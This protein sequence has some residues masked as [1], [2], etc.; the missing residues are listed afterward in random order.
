MILVDGRPG[1]C[2]SA[3]DRGFAY[4]DGVFRTMRAEAGAVLL[5]SE[6]YRKLQGDCSRL[7]IPCPEEDVLRADLGHV[8]GEMP[9]CAVKIIVTRGQ[10]ARGYAPPA[11]CEPT[12]VVA[13][14]PL[15]ANRAQSAEM[16]VRVRWCATRL[17]EQPLLAGVKHLNR[18]E[19]VLA[20][21][22]WDDPAI[23]EGLMCDAAGSVVDG[24]M[25]NV[26]I[27][28]NGWLVTPPL[29][30]CG[31]AGVQRDRLIALAD[32]LCNGCRIEPIAPARL[33]AAE[34]VY[35]VNSL[36]DAWW[37][38]ALDTRVWQ[39]C[40]LTPRLQLALARHA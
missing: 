9:T 39:R 7:D 34:Q 40:E 16:G 33:L 6:H 30:R 22:E 19:N 27:Y 28:E 4:G 26:F 38:A 5:W 3:L 11:A 10:G 17:S 8:L 32:K 25:S 36:I 23:A 37:V 21:R 20:R 1:T 12:R 29:D 14:F 15:P 18:L 35:L 24:T 31:V 2:I 13:G